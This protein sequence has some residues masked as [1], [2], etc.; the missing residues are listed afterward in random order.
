MHKFV[1][2]FASHVTDLSLYSEIYRVGDNR[3][4]VHTS[5]NPHISDQIGIENACKTLLCWFIIMMR[6]MV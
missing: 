6:V 3:L 2:F 5:T 4:T 1:E